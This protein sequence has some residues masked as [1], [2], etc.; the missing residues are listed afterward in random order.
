MDAL[1][2]IIGPFAAWYLLSCIRHPFKPCMWCGRGGESKST[3]YPG[4]FGTC[5]L[6]RGKGRRLRV[7]ARLMGR[8]A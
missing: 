4:A 2:W 5:R 8:K 3:S 6:C 7:G 1:L